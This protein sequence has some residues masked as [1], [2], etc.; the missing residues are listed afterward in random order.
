MTK[1][2]VLILASASPVFAQSVEPAHD[3]TGII[4]T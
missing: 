2:I 1:T 3:Q 4:D